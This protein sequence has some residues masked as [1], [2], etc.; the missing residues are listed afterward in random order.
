MSFTPSTNSN[1]SAFW[2][3]LAGIYRIIL[4]LKYLTAE[5][6]PKDMS[7][8]IACNGK[9]AVDCLN[10]TKLI[11]ASEAH[12]D[13]LSAIQKLGKTHNQLTDTCERSPRYGDN[14]ST[15]K[16]SMDEH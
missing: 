13:L 4:T 6:E 15:S 7:I 1:Q 2:S 12:D 11:Q 5:W 9:L 16:N 3:K 8:L 10:F 14:N